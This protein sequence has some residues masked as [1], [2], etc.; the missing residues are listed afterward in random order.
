MICMNHCRRRF[1]RAIAA[2]GSVGAAGCG[3]FESG[4]GD[5]RQGDLIIIV[6]PDDIDS[7][8]EAEAQEIT[9]TT[10]VECPTNDNIFFEETET[11]TQNP[12]S[13]PSPRRY[14]DVYA[15]DAFRLIFNVHDGPTKTE[16]HRLD[17]GSIR[18]MEIAY[19]VNGAIE[20]SIGRAVVP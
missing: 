15:T 9:A 1:F 18:E 7:T 11:F 5:D 12:S 4:C 3:Q 2:A 8:P 16:E 13:T 14:V 6:V 10:T 19:R 17:G 20:F